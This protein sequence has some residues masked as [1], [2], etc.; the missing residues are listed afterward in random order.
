MFIALLALCCGNGS[1]SRIQE[2]AF[3]SLVRIDALRDGEWVFIGSGTYVEDAV[4]ETGKSVLTAEHV[5]AN[6]TALRLCGHYKG[7]IV[8]TASST[9]YNK[10]GLSYVQVHEQIATPAKVAK[11]PLYLT[12]PVFVQGWPDGNLTVYT[13][14]VVTNTQGLY[15]IVGGWCGHGIS[16][17]GVFDSSG[18]LAGLVQAM[19]AY[20]VLAPDGTI[21]ELSIQTVCFA[22]SLH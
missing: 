20:E 5:P 16:G 1:E 18:H 10:D 19:P 8:C 11:L 15:A 6:E 13:G 4:T 12:E 9:F 22:Q 3:E 14:Q 17:G 7:Q 21:Q 2:H